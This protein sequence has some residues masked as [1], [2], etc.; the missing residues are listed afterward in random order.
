MKRAWTLQDK[1]PE[2]FK[3]LSE[4]EFFERTEYVLFAKECLTCGI[5]YGCNLTDKKIKI[6]LY[7]VGMYFTT[8]TF[9]TDFTFETKGEKN[10]IQ[11][12]G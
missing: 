6:P 8:Y 12:K 4:Q 9:E 10:A 11:S 1:I 3:H 2:G 5:K 7:D